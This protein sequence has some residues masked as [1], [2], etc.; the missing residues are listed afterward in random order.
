[1]AEEI[2]HLLAIAKFHDR[3]VVPTV[4]REGLENLYVSKG[5]IR[6]PDGAL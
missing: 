6:I 1:M 3:F 5:R 2:Y 4:R